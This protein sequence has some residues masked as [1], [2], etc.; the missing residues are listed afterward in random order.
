MLNN[1]EVE[2]LEYKMAEEFLANLKKEFSGRDE[3]AVKIV[4]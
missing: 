2:N 3:K 1:L 4:E